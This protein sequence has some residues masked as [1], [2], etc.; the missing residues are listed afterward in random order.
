L[1]AEGL[2]HHQNSRLQLAHGVHAITQ[3]G[4]GSDDTQTPRRF[5]QA[6]KPFHGNRF[7]VA[8]HNTIH[9][10]TLRAYRALFHL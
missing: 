10:A 3:Q 7:G 2:I 5:Q 1:D 6:S 8:N 4:L 9:N